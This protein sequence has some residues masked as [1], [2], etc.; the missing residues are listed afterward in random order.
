MRGCESGSASVILL[1]LV[2]VNLRKRVTVSHSTEDC[3]E[4]LVITASLLG[5]LH[6][7]EP[8]NV[9][10]EGNLIVVGHI[11]VEEALEV[12]LLIGTEPDC[13]SATLSR[14]AVVSGCNQS[15]CGAD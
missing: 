3:E 9:H 12:V 6:S 2:F 13:D 15:D 14:F 11:V 7:A 4:L 10:W 1:E 8:V 5:L